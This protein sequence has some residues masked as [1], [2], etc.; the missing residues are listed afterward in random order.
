MN[1]RSFEFQNILFKYCGLDLKEEN[2]FFKRPLKKDLFGNV[3]KVPLKSTILSSFLDGD[4]KTS[5]DGSV[6]D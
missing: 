5:K 1:Q 6:T 3:K 2:D 4:K